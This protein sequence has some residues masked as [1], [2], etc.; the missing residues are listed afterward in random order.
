MCCHMTHNV[1]RKSGVCVYMSQWSQ[2]VITVIALAKHFPSLMGW[3]DRG[4]AGAK[5]WWG[6]LEAAL[7]GERQFVPVPQFVQ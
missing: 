3:G 5:E 2:C 7:Q 1:D 4:W 6:S